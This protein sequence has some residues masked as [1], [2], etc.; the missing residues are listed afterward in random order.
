MPNNPADRYGGRSNGHIKDQFSDTVHLTKDRPPTYT[1]GHYGQ[2][3]SRFSRA[4]PTYTSG[5]DGQDDGSSSRRNPK[6]WSRR[7]WI[8]LAAVLVVLLLIIIIIAVVVSRANRYPDYSKLNYNLV[9][10]YSGTSFFDNF[11]YFT[12]Y[13]PA[14]GFVQYVC[15]SNGIVPVLTGSTSVMLTA[16]APLLSILPT[17]RLHQLSYGSIFR[18]QTLRPAASR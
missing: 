10:T 14:Q 8:L 5:V 1:S 2:E 12:G 7:C 9:D 17:L 6:N 15:N 11:N 13:D 18:T 3:S 4:A 16:Q